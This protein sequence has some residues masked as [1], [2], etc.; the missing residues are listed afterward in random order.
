MGSAIHW[1]TPD[2]RVALGHARLS[3][4]DLMTGDQPIASE[5]DGLGCFSEKEYSTLRGVPHAIEFAPK[6][7]VRLAFNW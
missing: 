1:I 7:K 2:R 4:I 6:R 5:D 3:I